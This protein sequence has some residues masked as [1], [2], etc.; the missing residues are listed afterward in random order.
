M[1]MAINRYKVTVVC[2]SCKKQR[3][4]LGPPMEAAAQAA[5]GAEMEAEWMGE[6][7]W[8]AAEEARRDGVC[9]RLTNAGAS[10]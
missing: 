6:L 9:H 10:A 5:G 1:K 7:G 4:S 2:K 3:L 8:Q